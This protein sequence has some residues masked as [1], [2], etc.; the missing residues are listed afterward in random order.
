M[1]ILSII[2]FIFPQIIKKIT[3]HVYFCLCTHTLILRRH[4]TT[5]DVQNIRSII[6]TEYINN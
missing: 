1:Y 2:L 5:I 3:Q 4:A 6:T